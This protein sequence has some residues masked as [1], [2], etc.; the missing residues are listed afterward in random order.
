MDELKLRAERYIENLKVA[1][2]TLKIIKETREV[3]KL[4]DLA[5]RYLEDSKYYFEKESFIDSIVCSTYSEGLLNALRELKLIKFEW[6]TKE[7]L[8]KPKVLIAGTFD[9]LHPGHIFLVKKASELGKVYVVV[10][11]DVNVEKFKGKKPIN[12]ENQRLYVIS[13]V[14]DVYKAI[15]GDEKDI[16]KSVEKI[17]PQIILLGPDQKISEKELLN[18]LKSRGL[19]RV[20]ILRLGTKFNKYPNCSSSNIVRRIME[21]YCK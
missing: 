15:L 6:P 8:E 7:V 14:K 9:I 13:N 18:M 17:N 19:S 12:D 3:I 1:F 10:A 5:K 11:R 16:I 21:L 20:K 2:N 4:I